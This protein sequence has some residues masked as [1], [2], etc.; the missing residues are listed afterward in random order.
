MSQRL[1]SEAFLSFEVL[2]KEEREGGL[3][4]LY[5]SRNGV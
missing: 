5:E 1:S 3:Q 4:K 2:T